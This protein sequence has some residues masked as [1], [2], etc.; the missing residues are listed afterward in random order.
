MI[1]VNELVQEAYEGLNMTGIGES[2]DGTMAKVGE[3][4]L[5]RLIS[6]L[7]SEGFLSLMQKSID[8]GP[9]RLIYFRK[10]E[11]GEAPQPNSIDMA[12]PE[13]IEAV[14]RRIG[15]TF[16]PLISTDPVLMSQKN[17]MTIPYGW[18]YQR[19][20][21][22]IPAEFQTLDKMKREVGVLMLDG[23]PTQSIRIWYSQPMPKYTL[24]DRI[25][26]SDLYN[27]LLLS[28]L[29]YRLAQFYEL[30]QEKI[31]SCYSD[32]IAAQSLIKRNNVTQ[33]MLREGRVGGSYRE[34]YDNGMAGAGW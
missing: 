5:N 22:D 21:E 15:A 17:P 3:Q 28:G 12:P 18:C 6:G 23:T 33:R 9:A 32:F 31:N 24:D 7:N 1:A 20:I 26:L 11:P 29:K 25:Y 14:S 27:E 4:Q 13:K 8:H 16:V 2:T 30:G 10:L 34:S 19:E